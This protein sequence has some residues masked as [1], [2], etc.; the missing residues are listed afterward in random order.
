MRKI[1][2]RFL[3]LV[4]V[5]V[6]SGFSQYSI[7]Q[8]GELVLAEGQAAIIAGNTVIARDKA[9]DDALRKAVEQTVGAVVSS[10]TMSENF[11]VVHDRILAH[12]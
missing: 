4:G 8:A 11:K 12:R 5:V 6:V 7:S 1:S 3:F 2:G 10:G 9:I